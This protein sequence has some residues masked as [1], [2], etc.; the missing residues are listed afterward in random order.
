MHIHL[1]V[2]EQVMMVITLDMDVEAEMRDPQEAGPLTQ[3]DKVLD[4]RTA[5]RADRVRIP[6]IPREAFAGTITVWYFSLSG[7]QS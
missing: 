4:T 3:M 5:A 6:M 1:K 7:R 2:L